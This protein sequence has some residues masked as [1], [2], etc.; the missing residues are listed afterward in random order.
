MVIG[1]ALAAILVWLSAID[2]RSQILPDTLTLPLLAAGLV[3]AWALEPWALPERAAAA[4]VGWGLLG[5]L[6]VGWHRLTGRHGLGGGD[7]K[8]VA[9]AGA[10]VG[11]EGMA[12]VI[13]LGALAGLGFIGTAALVSGGWSPERRLPFGPFLAAGFFTVWV[14]NP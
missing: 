8:L 2:W 3:L 10:W 1:L 13:L 9:A 4:A 14:I 5:G 7:A 12:W 6:A 11:L